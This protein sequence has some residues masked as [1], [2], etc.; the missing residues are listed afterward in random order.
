MGFDFE[1]KYTSGEQIHHANALSRMNF[2]EDVFDN[3]R[4]CFAIK[5]I[6]FAQSDLVTQA[7]KTQIETNRLFQDIMKKSIAAIGNRKMFRSGKKILTT[8]WCTDH[9]Q[10][11]HIPRCCYFHSNQTTTLGFSAKAH[12]THPEKNLTESS[13]RMIA[14]W[15]GISQDVQHSASKCKNCQMN[16]PI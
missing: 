5:N 9:T 7:E 11:N 12:E 1:Q 14:W 10:W 2:Y 13:F 16:R 15:P 6:Y 8:Q 3:D 4:V